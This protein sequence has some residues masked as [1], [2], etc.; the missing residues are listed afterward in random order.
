MI[1]MNARRVWMRSALIF[2]LAGYL[3]VNEAFAAGDASLGMQIVQQSELA[4][5]LQQ[6]IQQVQ[7]QLQMVSQG[8][9]NLQSLGQQAWNSVVG[10]INEMNSIVG[11]AQGLAYKSISTAAQIKSTFGDPTGVITGYQQKLQGW[12]SNNQAQMAGVMQVYNKSGEVFRLTSSG[13]E[14]AAGAS[15]TAAGQLQ[16]VQAGNQI[17]AMQANQIAALHQTIQSTSQVMLD[18]MAADQAKDIN[19]NNIRNQ[20]MNAPHIKGVY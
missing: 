17:A 20:I 3:P 2:G 18:K 1:N 6:Q 16:A 4:A 11:Q 12:V 5:Q 9:K 8:A 7:A 13:I 15:Q 19:D 14:M 10:P